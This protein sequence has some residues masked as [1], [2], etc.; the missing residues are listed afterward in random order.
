MQDFKHLHVWQRAHALAIALH[1]ISADFPRNGH[2]HLKA[3]LT[4][5]ADSIASNIVE[6]CGAETNKEF[7]RFLDIAIKS[8][9]E[10][11]Y[12]LL[13]ARDLDV[14]SPEDWQRYTS[15]TIEIRK[16]TFGYRKK[17]ASSER[18]H[19]PSQV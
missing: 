5:A 15:E 4:R 2:A 14:L 19:R 16:M 7:A 11:E 13:S 3:Q 18:G 10:T 17:I 12:H 8:A 6:G 1:K 9:N